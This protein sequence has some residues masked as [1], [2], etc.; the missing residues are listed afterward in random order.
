MLL[1]LAARLAAAQPAICRT[2]RTSS[3]P[4]PATT[5]TGE[6]TTSTRPTR[7]RFQWPVLWAT[8]A[9]LAVGGS[10]LW[11]CARRPDARPARRPST[12]AEELAASIDDA[13][14][15]LEAEPDAR[16]RSSPPTRAWSARS[17]AAASAARAERD[18][19][20]VSAPGPARAD[21]E[22]RRGQPADRAVRAGEVQP[23]RDRLA[24]E[25]RRNRGAAR[26][27]GRL[28]ARPRETAP[29]RRRRRDRRG[30]GRGGTRDLHRARLPYGR[31]A[32][33]RDRR[34]DRSDGA[35]RERRPHRAATQAAVAVRR[36]ARCAPRGALR[37]T[38]AARS[39]SNAR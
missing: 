21:R 14:D 27:S 4:R 15:D 12:V 19:A 20:R 39:A 18:A 37:G 6:R 38:G 11:W 25:A 8:L 26:D 35:R 5:L 10:P 31:A 36:R 32:H 33:L 1:G 30:N 13:I 2:C 34:R 23:A 17:T 24:D 16:G 3:R 28:L 9:V 22:R 7:R 29:P